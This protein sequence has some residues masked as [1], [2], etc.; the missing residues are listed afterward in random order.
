MKRGRLPLT[1]L[2]SFEAAGRHLS[3]SR[4]AEELFVSQAAISRQV[5]ELET[6]LGADL[7][8]RL[9]RKVELTETGRALLDDLTANFDR[10][11]EALDRAGG[12]S[13]EH[14]VRLTVDP[15]IAACWLVPRLGR[16]NARYPDIELELI[17]DSRV[18]DFR[19]GEAD[20]GLRFSYHATS[21]PDT[22]LIRL[23]D[24]YETPMASPALLE[25]RKP[26]ASPAD[27]QGLGL[28][29]EETRQHW[30]EWFR[31][32]GVK[33][34][35]KPSGPLLSDPALTRQAALLGHGIM[36]GDLFLMQDDLERGALVIPF[37]IF[38]R[39]GTYWI[40]ARRI[41]SL[42]QAARDVSDWLQDEVKKTLA[43]V[44][45]IWQRK[46]GVNVD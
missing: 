7:F 37:D 16:F 46:A 23:A 45:P 4:A 14:T 11:G 13:R 18:V 24:A 20:L 12:K 25:A 2:R 26:L 21:W 39:V 9:H 17:A 15:A 28:L 41:S 44:E 3:F 27:L 35:P 5:R 38:V 22:E 30:V 43:I 40:A 1:A 6:L 31:L 33:N 42:S 36:L 29:H 8:V 34:Q 10:I 32:A 19:S